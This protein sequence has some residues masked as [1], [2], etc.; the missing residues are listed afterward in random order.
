MIETRLL[1]Q[2]IVVAE[3]LHFNRAANR[4]NMA[5][6]PLSQAIKRLEEEIGARLLER[7]NRNVTLTG[8]GQDFLRTARKLLGE[9]EEGVENAR[10]IA[11][12]VAGRLSVSFIDTA[13]LDFLPQI[14]RSFRQA[15]PDVQLDLHEGTTAHQIKLLQSATMDA[16]FMRWPGTPVTGLVFKRVRSE[17]VLVALPAG[18]RLAVASRVPLAALADE[19]FIASPRSE[20]LGFHDQM[21][22]LCRKAGYSPRI[23]QFANQMQTIASLVAAGI[24]AALVPGSLAAVRRDDVVFRRIEVDAPEHELHIDLVV[25]WRAEERGAVLD[26]FLDLVGS[27]PP[28]SQELTNP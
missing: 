3:E 27:M 12:G 15:Y 25:C 2:F 7:D 14:L 5:Q 19:N 13:H 18:H 17:A 9:L 23:V 28:P 8:A 24:G 21:V 16:G 4:L 6:P 20:G 26:R 22:G 11:S 10:R 1:R